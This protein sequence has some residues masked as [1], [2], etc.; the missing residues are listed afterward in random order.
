LVNIDTKQRVKISDIEFKD[1]EVISETK[2][3]KQ[4]EATHEKSIFNLFRSSKYIPSNLE[5]DKERAIA[6]YRSKGYLDA[7]FTGQTI[8]K[9]EN[10]DVQLVLQVEDGK[11]SYSRNITWTGNSVYNEEPLQKVVDV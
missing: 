2:L 6:Y 5:K 10:G 3:R 7:G 9:K 8:V 4:F 1:N 11:P